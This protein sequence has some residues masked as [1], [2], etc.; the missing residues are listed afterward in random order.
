MLR[1]LSAPY[2]GAK[3]ESAT[4]SKHGNANTGIIKRS[5]TAGAPE[6]GLRVASSAAWSFVDF[7]PGSDRPSTER[8]EGLSASA[9]QAPVATVST[10]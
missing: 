7:P 9:F 1:L 10:R 8:G 4:R 5:T 6:L 2:A 3:G